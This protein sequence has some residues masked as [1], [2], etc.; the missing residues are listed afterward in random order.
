MASGFVTNNVKIHAVKIQIQF[1]SSAREQ[2]VEVRK[3]GS[4]ALRKGDF[5][6]QVVDKR[7]SLVIFGNLGPDPLQ[8]DRASYV[9]P[10]STIC[11][12]SGFRVSVEHHNLV[13]IL[14]GHQEVTSRSVQC[15][16]A[17]RFS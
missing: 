11:Q 16:I 13:A 12:L 3:R 15:K 2:A 17:W 6:P 1:R 7:H 14:I 10:V 4:F 9:Y 5:Y 8:T